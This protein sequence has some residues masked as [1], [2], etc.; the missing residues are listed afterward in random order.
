MMKS[1]AIADNLGIDRYIAQQVYYSLIGR[2]Y[3]YELMPLALD[4]GVGAIIWSPLGG[5]RLTGKIQ[6]G[7][8]IPKLS[9]LHTTKEI[10]PPV[11][12]EILFNV[13]DALIELSEETGKTIPQIA[14]NW[15]L[16]KPTVCSVIIGVRTEEQ[17]QQNLGA[18]G[19][20]L[21]DKQVKKLDGISQQVLP[22][23]YWHQVRWK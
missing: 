9:R 6:R 14:L 18:V 2:D 8:P 15:L 20:S 19:W 23:P 21:T 17:L 7:K 11:S 13:V 22:Y 3:E 12:E 5:A 10:G 4:Q 1:L 16:Q